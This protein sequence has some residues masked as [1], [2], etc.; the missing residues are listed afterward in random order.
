MIKC[1]LDVGADHLTGFPSSRFIQMSEVRD[2]S[3]KLAVVYRLGLSGVV[4]QLN[5][6][7]QTKQKELR[8]KGTDRE[9]DA[10]QSNYHSYKTLMS[11]KVCRDSEAVTC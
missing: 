8:R 1:T 5:D 3:L 6:E 11:S 10:E 9:T 4:Q 7:T 2:V